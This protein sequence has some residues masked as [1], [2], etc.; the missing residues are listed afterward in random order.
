MTI[1]HVTATVRGLPYDPKR[2]DDANELAEQAPC[3]HTYIEIC[4]QL[5]IIRQ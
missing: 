4:C 2:S 1:V 3:T 5:P